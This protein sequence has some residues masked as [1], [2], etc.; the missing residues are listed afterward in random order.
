MESMTHYPSVRRSTRKTNPPAGFPPE[1]V[2]SVVLRSVLGNGEAETLLSYDDAV[3]SCESAEWESAMKDEFD[4]IRDKNVMS[5][6]QQLSHCR[7]VGNRWLYMRE[8]DEN[9]KTSRYRARLVAKGFTQRKGI[10]H[11]QV[12]SPVTKYTTLRD[13]LSLVAAKKLEMLQLDVRAA[14]LSG[15]LEEDI[16][17]SQPQRFVFEGKEEYVYKLHKALYG[18][19]RASRYWGKY[20]D[21]VLKSLWSYV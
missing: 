2:V 8:R 13:V 18:L 20:L 3:S 17:M 15:E 1:C 19:K 21:G 7:A 4:Q 12:F 9:E 6:V 16:Y 14:F 10:D 11:D 5:L